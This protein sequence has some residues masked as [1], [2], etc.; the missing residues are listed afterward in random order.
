MSSKTILLDCMVTGVISACI[1]KKLIKIGEILCSLFN[2]EDGKNYTMFSAYYVLLFPKG[3]NTTET[4]K[5]ICAEYGGGA[6]T[7]Q[8]CQK[9]FVK[10]CAGDFSLDDSPQSGWPAE[11]D[12]NQIETLTENN[13]C[14]TTQETANILKIPKSI[15]LLMHMK[16]V[17]FILQKKP[18][19][20][21]GQPNINLIKC[22]SFKKAFHT[23]D[24]T[25]FKAGRSFNFIHSKNLTLWNTAPRQWLDNRAPKFDQCFS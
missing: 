5:K 1:S 15:R 10:F 20:L 13:Q 7:G 14:Y 6:V 9:W 24:Y 18:Y 25:I 23:C 2:I 3:K 22:L 17:S 19:E 4:H 8:T 21:F 11:V 16:N 12:R